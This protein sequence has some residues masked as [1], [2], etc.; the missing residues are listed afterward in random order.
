MQSKNANRNSQLQ[1]NDLLGKTKLT[2]TSIKA[3]SFTKE[4]YLQMYMWFRNDSLHVVSSYNNHK[5]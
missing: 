5:I 4:E 2:R 1:V 3:L